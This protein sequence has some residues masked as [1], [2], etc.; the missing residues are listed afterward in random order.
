MSLDHLST[1]TEHASTGARTNDGRLSSLRISLSAAALAILAGCGGA[2][3]SS[4][5]TIHCSNGKTI[6]RNS[7]QHGR[8]VHSRETV[9]TSECDD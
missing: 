3:V 2:T 8:N 4:S 6:Q 1:E 9:S 5:S 7:T